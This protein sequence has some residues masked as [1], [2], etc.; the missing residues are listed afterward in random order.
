MIENLESIHHEVT[1]SEIQFDRKSLQNRS[2]E[3]LIQ[4]AENLSKGYYEKESNQR[5]QILQM[6]ADKLAENSV[7]PP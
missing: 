3:E 5:Q 4:L 1:H 2:G 7:R 6:I